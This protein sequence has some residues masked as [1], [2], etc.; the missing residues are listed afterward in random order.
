[1]H[2]RILF[3]FL[4]LCSTSYANIK[5]SGTDGSSKPDNKYEQNKLMVLDCD[6]DIDVNSEVVYDWKLGDGIDY[7][8][9]NGNKTVYLA[10]IPGKHNVECTAIIKHRRLVTILVR[11]PR[12]PNDIS[13][14]KMEDIYVV[15]K[16]DVQ[17]LKESFSVGVSPTP[18]PG[19]GPDP[20]PTPY[21]PNPG[22]DIIPEPGFN[23]VI[24]EETADRVILPKGV[25][26]VLQ[27][28]L[29]R[30]YVKSKGGEFDQV[31]DDQINSNKISAKVKGVLERQ[32]ESIPWI[33]ISNDFEWYEG[34]LPDTV[35]KTIDL[36]D[37]YKPR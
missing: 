27:S 11:D 23:V 24:I 2:Y 16:V 1:M 26:A 28:T 10:A 17:V 13:K 32:R 29:P 15:D 7:V 19:P 37:K 9:T 25:V 21:P 33:V 8:L 6:L 34:P 36:L 3:A 20:D 12:D 4:L 14:A 31:D 5:I 18:E 35:E 22:E 30:N